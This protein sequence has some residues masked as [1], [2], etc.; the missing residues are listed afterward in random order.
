MIDMQVYAFSKVCKHLQGTLFLS[1]YEGNIIFINLT[2]TLMAINF[3]FRLFKEV[4][5][6]NFKKLIGTLALQYYYIL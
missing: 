4:Y 2:S 1:R 6:L 5:C 3:C